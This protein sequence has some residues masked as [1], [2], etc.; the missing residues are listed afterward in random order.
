MRTAEVRRRDLNS[1]RDPPES[2]RIQE[3]D[4]QTGGDRANPGVH[5]QIQIP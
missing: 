2:E 4:V 5:L 3:S 1:L